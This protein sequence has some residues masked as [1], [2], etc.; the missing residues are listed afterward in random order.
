[1]IV[2]YD[3]DNYESHLSRISHLD[4]QLLD[5][6]AGQRHFPESVPD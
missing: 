2:V 5:F 3:A 1:M 4:H 6:F